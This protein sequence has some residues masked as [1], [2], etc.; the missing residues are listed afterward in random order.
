M[1]SEQECPICYEKMS[2]P[3]MLPCRHKFCLDCLKRTVDPDTDQNIV[4]CALCRQKHKLPKNGIESF[5]SNISGPCSHCKYK[6]LQNL[7]RNGFHDAHEKSYYDFTSDDG[8]TG[9]RH[10]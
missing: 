1:A 4:K 9:K 8:R 5:P 6:N 7:I 3:K 10:S 2:Q